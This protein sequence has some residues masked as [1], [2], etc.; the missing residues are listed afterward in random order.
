M[1]KNKTNYPA[2]YKAWDNMKQR[3]KKN[4]NY[5]SRNIK[6]CNQW[7]IFE[8]FFN[9]MYSTYKDG[10]TLDRIDNNGDY[11]PLNCRWTTPTIQSRNTRIISSNNTSG[12]RGVRSALKDK[13]GKTILWKSVIVVNYKEVYL[14]CFKNPS[15]GARV[16]DKYVKENNLEHRVNGL[17][18]EN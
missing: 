13:N 7:E 1:K 4:K 3:V 9:D 16:Y 17:E 14:G 5:I 18:C 11:E 10:L 2:L 8:G 12:F 6:Y 15:D